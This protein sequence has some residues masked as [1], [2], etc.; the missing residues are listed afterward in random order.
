MEDWG[1]DEEEAK[2]ICETIDILYSKHKEVDEMQTYINS[3]SMD[4][5]A[6]K[7]IAGCFSTPLKALYQCVDIFISTCMKLTTN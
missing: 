1:Y 3:H 2:N 4:Q 5:S 6:I 7:H